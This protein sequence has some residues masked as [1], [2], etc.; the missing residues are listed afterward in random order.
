MQNHNFQQEVLTKLQDPPL[1]VGEASEN[2]MTPTKLFKKSLANQEQFYTSPSF[3]T[4]DSVPQ[5]LEKSP[6]HELQTST[7][8]N[9]QD[10]E[11]QDLPFV[12]SEQPSKLQT[13]LM[14]T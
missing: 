13:D 9:F 4:S 3:V 2:E 11:K 14:L 5:S 7:A 8:N 6:K 10:S 1:R 12:S